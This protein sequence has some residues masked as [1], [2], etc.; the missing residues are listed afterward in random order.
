MKNR[1]NCNC[2]LVFS[3]CLNYL[4]AIVM[5]VVCINNVL[6]GVLSTGFTVVIFTILLM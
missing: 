4:Y 6:A 1:E 2:N 3:T 5:V